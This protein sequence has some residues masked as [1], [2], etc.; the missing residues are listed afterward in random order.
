[1]LALSCL[2][3]NFYFHIFQSLD[4]YMGRESFSFSF[5]QSV[6]ALIFSRGVCVAVTW[7]SWSIAF[8]PV[9]LE[10]LRRLSTLHPH[11]PCN[12]NH[13]Q[14]QQTFPASVFLC[15]V[16]EVRFVCVR[17]GP[18]WTSTQSLFCWKTGT[19]A[20][21]PRSVN[22]SLRFD[23]SMRSLLLEGQ[24]DLVTA[25]KKPPSLAAWWP[26]FILSRP[27]T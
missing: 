3:E 15:A 2:L 19:G 1:M 13:C 6:S 4:V 16:Q 11:S 14:A 27:P 5:S 22:I 9:Y 24:T 18:V 23:R 21:S 7:C 10:N 8:Y 20:H 17:E 25:D 26:V 12:E